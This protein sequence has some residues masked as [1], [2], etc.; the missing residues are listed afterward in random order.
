MDCMESVN[1][2]FAG[3]WALEGDLSGSVVTAAYRLIATSS[4][5]CIHMIPIYCLI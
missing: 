5:A 4:A 1:K 2:D 3:G